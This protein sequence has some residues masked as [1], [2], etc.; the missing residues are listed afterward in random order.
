VKKNKVIKK[1][2]LLMEVCI[3]LFLV[4]I[5]LSCVFSF[6]SQIVLVEKKLKSAQKQVFQ[7]QYIQTKL[8]HIF[9]QITTFSSS[10]G[11]TCFYSNKI[12]KTLNI[13]YD[14]GID[15]D[16]NF[17]GPVFG[18]F[19]IN[20]KKDLIFSTLAIKNKKKFLREE[21]ILENVE[22][23]KFSFL[24]EIDDLDDKIYINKLNNKL[25]WYNFWPKERDFLPSVINLSIF[26]KRNIKDNK[27]T[28]IKY[29]FLLPS[30]KLPVTYIDKKS[31][32]I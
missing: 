18:K 23:V 1:S 8:K 30:N 6:F 7:N 20:S 3:S 16:P 19:Y 32:K 29:A 10:L 2:F 12:D 31:K 11:N 9:S 27:I 28:S 14:N 15:P 24:G 4:G 17:S 26:F 25:A 5:I 22:N 21:N 13:I